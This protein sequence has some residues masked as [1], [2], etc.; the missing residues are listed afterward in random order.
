MAAA[1]ALCGCGKSNKDPNQGSGPDASTH[2]PLGA[3]AAP[4]CLSGPNG[5]CWW[6]Y[7]HPSTAAAWVEPPSVK[8]AHA[9]LTALPGSIDAGNAG[10]GFSLDPGGQSIDLTPF[11]RIVVQATVSSEFEFTLANTSG[12]A[13][14]NRVFT[15]NGTRQTFELSFATCTRWSTGPAFDFAAVADMHWST[16]WAK[17]STVDIEVVPD[18]LF[19]RGSDCT[20][21]PLQPPKTIKTDAGIPSASPDTGAPP[22]ESLSVTFN[23]GKPS[24]AMNGWAWPT[25]G[26]DEVITEPLCLPNLVPPT[27]NA[28]CSAGTKWNSPTQLCLSGSTPAALSDLDYSQ[29]WG[30]GIAVSVGETEGTPLGRSYSTMAFQVSGVP[31]DVLSRGR[32]VVGVHR[33]GDPAGTMYLVAN[34]GLGQ[35]VR[36]TSMNTAWWDT[37]KGVFLQPAD[38]LKIDRVEINVMTDSVPFTVSNLCLSGIVFGK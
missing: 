33:A 34:N 27:I 8:G 36:L 19:C 2:N 31:A 11:D 3:D 13:G 26:Q 35:A 25:M 18:V 29:S 10:V 37:S 15:G 38:V 28:M 23:N 1:S 20:T 5:W 17:A 22:T 14:C 4:T 7:A 16:P 24:G 9:V 21:N 32:F 30:M 12:T 6:L